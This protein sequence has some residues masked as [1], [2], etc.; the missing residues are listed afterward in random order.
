MQMADFLLTNTSLRYTE[1]KFILC[2]IF[3]ELKK[4]RK[5]QR[6][7]GASFKRK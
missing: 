4:R 7:W 6:M 1:D 5:V 3:A 2:N